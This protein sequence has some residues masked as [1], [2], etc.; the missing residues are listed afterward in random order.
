MKK[1]LVLG[2][3]AGICLYAVL[4]FLLVGAERSVSGAGIQTLGDAFW[5]SLVTMTTVGYGDIYPVS[6]LGRGIGIGFLLLGVSALASALSA[7]WLFV[8]Q[9]LLP[10]IRRQRI[11][12]HDMYCFADISEG[13]LVLAADLLSR[14]KEIS[15]VFCGVGMDARAAVP[16]FDPRVSVVPEDP[17]TLMQNMPGNGKRH[18]FLMQ[19]DSPL[20]SSVQ[21]ALRES[22]VQVYL[23]GEAEMEKRNMHIFAPSVCIARDYWQRFPLLQNESQVILIGD[24]R[25]AR[26]LLDQAILC[27]ARIPFSRTAY[28]LYGDWADY[29][30]DHPG[31]TQ[32]FSM[33]GPCAEHDT[34]R[35]HTAS[36]KAGNDVWSH[37]DRVIFAYDEQARN[38]AEAT[39]LLQYFPFSGVVYGHASYL[40]E[41][42]RIFG[43]PEMMYT[44]SMIMHRSLDARARALH[45]MYCT[46]CGIKEDWDSL[47]EFLRDS[48]RASAD[49]LLTKIRLLLPERDIREIHPDI[50]REAA[51][52]WETAEDRDAYRHNEH[53]RWMRF[54]ALHNWRWGMTKNSEQRM[55]PCMV[56]YEALPME[57]RVKDDS[58]YRQIGLLGAEGEMLP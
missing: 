48:N 14:E 58:A 20:R 31:L 49:H 10:R 26:A 35:F 1:R 8:Q 32:V 54:F 15:V 21:D 23:C 56:P 7:A 2:V 53:E 55:H 18:V 25:L 30:L 44:S 41:P 17:A 57:E 28:D 42:A 51:A 19:Q 24:G 12:K 36:W 37:A 46:M 11:A 13:A 38:A 34:L 52:R 39:R 22:G 40:P 4:L 50:C 9:R 16:L 45:A 33:D 29:V 6:A 3:A 27:N 47:P 5:Y 43:S